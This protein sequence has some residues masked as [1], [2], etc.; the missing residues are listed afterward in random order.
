M[1]RTPLLL[2]VLLAALRGGLFNYFTLVFVTVIRGLKIA[3]VI[4]PATIWWFVSR[5]LFRALSASFFL[6]FLQKR[7]HCTRKIAPKAKT[8]SE[9]KREA[10]NHRIREIAGIYIFYSFLFSFFLF[11]AVS[12]L[13][14][15]S[16]CLCVSFSFFI[17]KPARM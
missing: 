7:N 9:T 2:Q 8:K 15:F 6:L 4:S 5:P 10:R 13:L 12:L 1:S 11:S 3:G 14:C 16:I 17:Q